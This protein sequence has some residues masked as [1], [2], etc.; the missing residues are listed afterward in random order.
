LIIF[1]NHLSCR[2]ED[3][4]VLL[5]LMPELG[6]RFFALST[7][8]SETIMQLL[9]F[10]TAPITIAPT[11]IKG[12]IHDPLA[13][14]DL[15]L[16]WDGAV[17]EGR[18]GGWWFAETLRLER[19]GYN[20]LGTVLSNAVRLAVSAHVNASQ[21]E[22]RF[23]GSRFVERAVVYLGDQTYSGKVYFEESQTALEFRLE[24]SVLEG[25]IGDL[26]VKLAA[27]GAPDWILLA[28]ALVAH[29]AQKEVSKALLESLD[30]MGER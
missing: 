22:V 28:A 25:K 10:G 26:P 19:R 11:R 4:V 6:Q 21:L 27:S 24:N 20:L 14:Y 15:A 9:G 5:L 30:S 8:I 17:L 2:H 1:V 16:R 29:A 23:S 7:H 12:A 3:V 13:R 18:L